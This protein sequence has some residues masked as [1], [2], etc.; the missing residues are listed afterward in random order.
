MTRAPWEDRINPVRMA[1]E[2]ALELA[3]QGIPVFPCLANKKP[4]C[5]HGFKQATSTP[6][7]V[8]ELWRASP[9]VRIG[10][11]TGEASGLF[12]LDVDT[13]R[14]PEAV[15]WHERFAQQLPQTRLHKT[16]S[17]GWHYLFQH[18]KGLRC[19]S[20]KIERGIDTRGD[21]GYIIWW[22]AHVVSIEHRFMP[23]APVPDWLV[24]AL[25]PKPV[26]TLS[27]YASPQRFADAPRR[28]EGILT[29]IAEARE[30][31][32]NAITFWG[33]CRIGE[34]VLTGELNGGDGARA[35]DALREAAQ[36]TGLHPSEIRRTIESALR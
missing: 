6:I 27:Y 13:A 22:P 9:G 31:E 21:G 8:E 24:E 4:A 14:H 11:P 33:A 34:M 5:R 29:K 17:G 30:G 10:V 1:L 15:Q 3:A 19:T 23:A 25:N 2:Q 18:H 20:S 26:H 7:E 12:C 16:E 28:L 35:F 32:R 36:R